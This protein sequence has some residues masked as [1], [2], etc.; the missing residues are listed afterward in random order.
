MDASGNTD[1][2]G[3]SAGDEVYQNWGIKKLG[4]FSRLPKV[5]DIT[6]MLKKR[7]TVSPMR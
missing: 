7:L 4:Y 3:D 5:W 1:V 6:L 2:S